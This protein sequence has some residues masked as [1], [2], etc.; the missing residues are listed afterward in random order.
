MRPWAPIPYVLQGTGQDCGEFFDSCGANTFIFYLN[1]EKFQCTLFQ[2]LSAHYFLYFNFL[3]SEHSL[4]ILQVRALVVHIINVFPFPRCQVVERLFSLLSD[5]MW[6]APVA[7]AKHSVH[8]KERE[9]ELKL[10]VSSIKS[11]VKEMT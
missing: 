1:A 7:Q 5:C 8:L 10:Q 3:C 6:E 4:G 9:Q 11:R 2:I